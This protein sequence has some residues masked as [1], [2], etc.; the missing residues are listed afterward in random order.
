MEIHYYE[1]IVLHYE[2][3]YIILALFFS[4]GFECR[5]GH[6]YCGIHRYADKHECPFDYR[7]LGRE[8]IEKHNPKVV[9]A[10]IQKI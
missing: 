4:V 6:V 9:A 1:I 8:Q 10:K 2:V 5:C 7:A 3:F